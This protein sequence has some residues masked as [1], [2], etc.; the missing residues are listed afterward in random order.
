MTV[1]VYCN[2]HGLF[3]VPN[4]N[5]RC[6]E[7]KPSDPKLT[8]EELDMLH[9]SSTAFDPV[10]KPEHYNQ[11]AEIECIDAMREIY[12]EEYFVR[13]CVMTAFKYIWRAFHKGDFKQ[14]IEKAI[15][16]LRMA[17]GDD[18]RAYRKGQSNG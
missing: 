14:N 4:W 15:W 18:P 13:H 10:M 11:S 12:G 6:P 9:S 5:A 17:I 7:C 1:E 3:Q 2:E 16:Y 8:Q